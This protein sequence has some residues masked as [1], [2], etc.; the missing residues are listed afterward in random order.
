MN[1]RV[2]PEGLNARHGLAACGERVA[3]DGHPGLAQR[4]GAPAT[5]Q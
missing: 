3:M 2:K 4:N 5:V 1:G